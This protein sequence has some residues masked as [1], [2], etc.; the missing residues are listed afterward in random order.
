MRESACSLNQRHNARTATATTQLNP[1]Q[2]LAAHVLEQLHGTGNRPSRHLEGR[3]PSSSR[4]PFGPLHRHRK[5]FE[6][7]GFLCRADCPRCRMRAA[8]QQGVTRAAVMRHS[9]GARYRGLGEGMP[10]FYSC[11]RVNQNCP[12]CYSGFLH[13]Q[14]PTRVCTSAVLH[15]EVQSYLDDAI[16]DQLPDNTHTVLDYFITTLFRRV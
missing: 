4:A 13:G 11:V 3:A 5:K 6:F 14:S 1:G 10:R 2:T 7:S 15:F 16:F 8:A 9:I 12:W